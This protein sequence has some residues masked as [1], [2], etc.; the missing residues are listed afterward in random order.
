MIVAAALASVEHLVG[1]LREQGWNVRRG[2]TLPG[3]PW[4]A[5]RARLV[6]LGALRTRADAEAALLAA[7]RGAGVVALTEAP[8]ALVERFYEDLRRFG[9]VELRG[10]AAPDPIDLLAA[11]ERRLLELLAD[12]LTVRDAARA[13]FL[14]RRTADRRLARARETLGARTTAEAV[15]E[16]VSRS[17]EPDRIGA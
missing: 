16:Y 1:R 2:W 11:D 17:G 5:S 8:R 9:A 6:C 14:S 13:L 4:D 12:G 3:R 15:T 10:D 7:A